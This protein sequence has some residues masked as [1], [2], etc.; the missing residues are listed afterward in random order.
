MCAH[1]GSLA[2]RLIVGFPTLPPGES[3]GG[4]V[5]SCPD[6]FAYQQFLQ[7][8]FIDVA[9][10]WR[11]RPRDYRF[12]PRSSKCA[13]KKSGRLADDLSENAIEVTDVHG[14]RRVSSDRKSKDIVAGFQSSRQSKS[15]YEIGS[16]SLTHVAYRDMPRR[17]EAHGIAVLP[18]WL[19]WSRSQ[20]PW[21]PR[22]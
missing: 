16:Q 17:A 22:N 3:E 7:S 21:I 18:G 13:T 9:S 4:F 6:N 15:L 12:E 20:I 14:L 2:R 5:Q 19:P 1:A 8:V 10:K 11:L